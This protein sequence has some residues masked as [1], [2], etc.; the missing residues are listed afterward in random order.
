MFPVSFWHQTMYRPRSGETRIFLTRKPRLCT[1]TTHRV[2]YSKVKWILVDQAQDFFFLKNYKISRLDE[3][4][5]FAIPTIGFPSAYVKSIPDGR[6]ESVFIIIVIFYTVSNCRT[7]YWRYRFIRRY[8]NVQ[9]Q[10][11]NA[12]FRLLQ[13]LSIRKTLKQTNIDRKHKI[14]STLFSTVTGKTMFS[15]Y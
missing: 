5:C 13:A 2:Y 8:Y 9:L 10:L 11:R 14:M 4:L 7:H 3:K 12:S 6:S 1:L 15:F